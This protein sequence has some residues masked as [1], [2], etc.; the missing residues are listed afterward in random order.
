VTQQHRFVVALRRLQDWHLDSVKAQALGGRSSEAPSSRV[1][2]AQRYPG[3]NQWLA[4]WIHARSDE[5]REEL[6]AGLEDEFYALGMSPSRKASRADGVFP[7]TEQHRR[8]IAAA[9]GSLRQVSRLW[10]VSKS[11]VQRYRK[12]FA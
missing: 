12:E 1:L 2:Q 6:I 7:G 4:R 5:Q 9:E 11:T 3:T 10:G 8:L